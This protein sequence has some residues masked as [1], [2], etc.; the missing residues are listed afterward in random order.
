MY[1]APMLQVVTPEA[2]PAIDELAGMCI[3]FRQIEANN[4]EKG[5]VK[6]TMNAPRR[7]PR[8]T[9]RTIETSMIPALKL[10]STVFVV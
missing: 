10:C 9:N 3:V 7:L 4:S 2:V 1:D 8:K 5:I 6:A